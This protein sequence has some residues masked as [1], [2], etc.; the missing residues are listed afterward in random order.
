LLTQAS[1]FGKAK[2]LR[3]CCDPLKNSLER[4]FS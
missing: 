1:P 2:G 4:V 3:L